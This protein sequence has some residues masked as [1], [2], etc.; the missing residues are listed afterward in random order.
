MKRLTFCLCLALGATLASAQ[1]LGPEIW[2]DRN[3]PAVN[4]E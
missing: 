3:T 1:T 4:K 2:T